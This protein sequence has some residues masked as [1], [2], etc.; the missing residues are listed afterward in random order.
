MLFF[1]KTKILRIFGLHD[2]D[3]TSRFP[4]G[5]GFHMFWEYAHSIVK[6]HVPRLRDC[7]VAVFRQITKIFSNT[8]YKHLLL[9]QKKWQCMY[10]ILQN[11]FSLNDS[12]LLIIKVWLIK[13]YVQNHNYVTALVLHKY[14]FCSTVVHCQNVSSRDNRLTRFNNR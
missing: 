8:D 7:W 4:R 6:R 5:I 1:D 2:F 9:F 14:I 10:K 3:A 11:I 12:S 13:R